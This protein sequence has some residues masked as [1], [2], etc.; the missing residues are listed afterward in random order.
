[1]GILMTLFLLSLTGIPP[2]A[3]FFAKAERHPGGRRGRWASSTSWPSSPCSNAAVA[4]FYYLRVVVYMFMR[5]G[6]PTPAL[7]HGGCCGAAWRWRP[8]SRSC[9]GSSRPRLLEA[10]NVAAQ[11]LIPWKRAPSGRLTAPPP[12]LR[13]VERLGVRV[14]VGVRR[15]FLRQRLG[16]EEQLRLGPEH[17]ISFFFI[18]SF[19]HSLSVCF[20]YLFII[21]FILYICI[22]HFVAIYLLLVC[23]LSCHCLCGFSFVCFCIFL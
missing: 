18:I 22:Y 19:I 7:R 17:T 6:A 16:L 9:S 10:A 5:E 4:A 3:G 23:P 12:P 15:R 1:M 13:A 8:R 11:A 21:Y 14:G 20:I 2:T